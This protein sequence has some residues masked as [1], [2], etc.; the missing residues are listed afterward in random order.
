MQ[1]RELADDFFGSIDDWLAPAGRLERPRDAGRDRANPLSPAL[2]K[3]ARMV[4]ATRPA[5]R[6]T[7]R[8]STISSRPT[9]G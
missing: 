2:E 6:T 9:I 3:L 7:K 8:S 4:Q 1:C 5:A